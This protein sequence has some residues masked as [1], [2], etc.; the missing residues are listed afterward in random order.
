MDRLTAETETE[1]ETEVATEE[2]VETAVEEVETQTE[3]KPE[4]SSASE[5]V[6]A[7]PTVSQNSIYLHS[8]EDMTVADFLKKE[9]E[10]KAK[11][12]EKEKE[13][14]IQQQYE[15]KPEPKKE[16]KEEKKE[17]SQKIIE[18]PNYDFLQEDSKIVKL[19]KKEKP[20]KKA[21]KKKLSLFLSIALGI[22]A[23]ICLT[24]VIV[25]DHL[26]NKLSNLEYDLYEVNLP[27]YLKNIADLDST[28][29]GMEFIETYPEDNFDAGEAGQKSNWFDKFCNFLSGLFGG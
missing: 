15:K 4:E 22:S 11:Q 13:K 24:N 23:V 18:K 6:E 25:I 28:K 10:E 3:T 14:L 1:E 20:K 27:Q 9:E 19:S 21:G 17:V 7:E 29:K 26:S 8:F 12:F 5:E 16:E 2:K